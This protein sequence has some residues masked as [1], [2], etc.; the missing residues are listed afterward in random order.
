LAL[1]SS[2]SSSSS[3]SSRLP[4]GRGRVTCLYVRTCS[5]TGGGW[6]AQV[7][8]KAMQQSR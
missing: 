5:S 3:A 1:H 6:N 7:H 4:M 2:S 8:F